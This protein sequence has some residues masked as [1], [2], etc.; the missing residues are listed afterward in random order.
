MTRYRIVKSETKDKVE[1]TKQKEIERFDVRL[2][3]K[4][5]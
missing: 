2:F 4:T 1:S 5:G 3:I